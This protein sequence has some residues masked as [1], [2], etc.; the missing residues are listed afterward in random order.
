MDTEV[1]GSGQGGG[2]EAT[3]TKGKPGQAIPH[4]RAI[5]AWA[6]ETLDMSNGHKP[7][8]LAIQMGAGTWKEAEKVEIT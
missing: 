1:K 4:K 5:P 3:Q 7:E 8:G 6:Q 2:Q